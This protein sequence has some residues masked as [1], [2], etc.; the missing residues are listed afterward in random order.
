[1]SQTEKPRPMRLVFFC[2]I[3]LSSPVIVSDLPNFRQIYLQAC[4]YYGHLAKIS[5]VRRLGF[6]ADPACPGIGLDICSQQSLVPLCAMHRALV[7]PDGTSVDV[8]WPRIRRYGPRT[9]NNDR[10]GG[11]RTNDQFGFPRHHPV[12]A[13]R[14]KT[15]PGATFVAGYLWDGHTQGPTRPAIVPP[16]SARVPDTFAWVKKSKPFKAFGWPCQG[17]RRFRVTEHCI[18]LSEFRRQ[19]DHRRPIFVAIMNVDLPSGF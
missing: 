9:P 14:G 6:C 19:S 1:M 5:A 2:T 4:Q 17:R 18:R 12:L 16:L 3:C 7:R 15:G 10:T 8:R 11:H 13:D